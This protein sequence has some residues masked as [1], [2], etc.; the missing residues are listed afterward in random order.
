MAALKIVV[1]LILAA[2]VC[3][4]AH[5]GKGYGKLRSKHSARHDFMRFHNVSLYVE[6]AG[7][8]ICPGLELKKRQE[9]R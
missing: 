9:H 4:G 7:I 2:S 8:R 3:Y 6:E 1:R 5:I